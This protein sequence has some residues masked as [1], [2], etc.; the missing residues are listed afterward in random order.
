MI[1]G[2]RR[3]M[4]IFPIRVQK[5][6]NGWEL[7]VMVL[8]S[9]F[10]Q[11]VLIFFGKWRKYTA[12]KW[13]HI[14]LWSAYL[15][16]DWVA[17]VSLVILANSQGDSNNNDSGDPNDALIALWAPFLLL[18]L[19]GP[20]TITAYSL[21]DNELWKRHFLGLLVQVGVAF[22]VFLRSW[23]GNRISFL[24]IP[25]FVPG[26]IK[27]GERTWVLWSASS[28]HFRKSMLN[29]Y[30]YL[31][32]SDAVVVHVAYSFFQ[33]FKRI[34]ADLFLTVFDVDFSQTYFKQISWEDAFKVVEMELG[35]MY[36]VLYTKASIVY[37]RLGCILRAISLSTTIS[38]FGVFLMVEKHGYSNIDIIITHILIVGAI[39]L[40]MYALIVLLSSDWVI[41]WNCKHQ[42]SFLNLML[43]LISSLRLTSNKRCSNSMGQLSL[44]S[45]CLKDKS[46]LGIHKLYRINEMLEKYQHMTVV[47]IS[48]DLKELIFQKLQEKSP[49]FSE[50]LDPYNYENNELLKEI[51]QFD[52][53]FKW[54]FGVQFE[55]SLLLWH[56]ATEICYYSDSK[57]SS[58]KRQVSKLISDYMLYLHIMRPFMLPKGA[59]L[60]SGGK[61]D[62]P[63]VPNYYRIWSE[64]IR[65]QDICAG[66]MQILEEQKTKSIDS[67]GTISDKIQACTILL[68]MDTEFPREVN[69]SSPNRWIEQNVK[70]AQKQMSKNVLLDGIELAKSL[71]RTEE[72]WKM[73][74]D[75]WLEM[76]YFAA[77]KC[78]GNYHAQ[79][80][81]RGGQLLTH[82]A[83]HPNG[84]KP[85][86]L[87]MFGVFLT[88]RDETF[89][90]HTSE[91]LHV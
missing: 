78:R 14:I 20:D 28:E 82:H 54:I 63:N 79:Q 2:K 7:R 25:I 67:D 84:L 85:D 48:S 29:Q 89:V 57:E 71:Q 45:F 37:T 3:V 41:V 33:V 53:K 42:N 66:A 88:H 6:W 70:D 18:H 36:D 35:F 13:V 44:L 64:Q 32:H 87:H 46:T 43:R 72:R 52:E 12:K 38:L 8:L 23:T 80:L 10:L 91:L 76:L 77:I 15:S 68:H 59:A 1:S 73:M 83:N 26:I 30:H 5:L 75:V 39:V 86:R 49:N 19:G 17:T 61:N 22:Y 27:Y 9:L 90:D 31:S 21:E 74:R 62:L 69:L 50:L 56:I 65:F 51:H 81:G 16:A 40:E 47:E 24:A 11:I 4:E 55:R 34:F 58:S 60:L